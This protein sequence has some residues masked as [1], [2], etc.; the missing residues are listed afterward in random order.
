MVV[1]VR[2]VPSPDKSRLFAA[3][4]V[5]PCS[6]AFSTLVRDG[7]TSQISPHQQRGHAQGTVRLDESLAE[8]VRAGKVDAS[9]ARAFADTPDELDGLLGQKPAPSAPPPPAQ[10]MLPRKN[11][12]TEEQPVDLGGLLSKA[13]S[14]FGS[15]KG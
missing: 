7:K 14:L 6:P 13:G 12:P 10:G 2:L 15:K 8:L 11:R 5:L 4:E 3:V 1:G 9:T